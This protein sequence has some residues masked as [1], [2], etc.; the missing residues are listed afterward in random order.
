MEKLAEELRA[1]GF[2]MT[3]NTVGSLLKAQDDSLQAPHRTWEG[4][5]HP[6]RDAQFRHI[7]AEVA[8]M[9]AAEQPV[10][11]VDCKKKE[12]V[13]AFKNQGREYQIKGQP[14]PV[15]VYD[16]AS[17]AL[18]KAIPYGVYDVTRN[19]GWVRVG[20]DHDTSEFA[21]H[22][23]G[24]WWRRMGK[25]RYKQA[26]ELLIT[27]DGGGS[28]GS[29]TRTWKKH[30]QR[31]ADR[32]GMIVH[33]CHFPPGTSKWNKIEHRLFSQITMNWRGKPLSTLETVVGLIANT[34]TKT[35][36][37]VR[38]EGDPREYATGRRVTDAEMGTLLVTKHEFHGEWNYTL[39]PRRRKGHE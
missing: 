1:E 21:V 29:R 6:D 17:D 16:F 34:K 24:P 9:Q 33:V 30:L 22:S 10:I 35:G 36:L 32:T 23:I 5:D 37:T 2:A 7:A 31:F 8:R 27:A 25:S 3:A 4:G 14:V 15:N 18:F 28:N 20:I 38:A 12:L 19:E 13:G 39:T 26:K 11:S